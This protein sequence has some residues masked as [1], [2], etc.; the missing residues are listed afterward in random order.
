M[1]AT[2]RCHIFSIQLLGGSGAFSIVQIRLKQPTPT[3]LHRPPAQPC[4]LSLPFL[5]GLLLVVVVVVLVV[6]VLVLVLVLLVVLVL[7][8]RGS[9][10]EAAALGGLCRGVAGSF[11]RKKQTPV[12]AR[13]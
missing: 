2:V 6:L 12:T 8:T 5:P 1:G 4:I 11:Q 13:A 10:S 3:S 9:V 7:V